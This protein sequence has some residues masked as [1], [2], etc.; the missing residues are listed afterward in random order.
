VCPRKITLLRLRSEYEEGYN[1]RESVSD[2]GTDPVAYHCFGWRAAMREF[3]EVEPVVEW[4]AEVID[5]DGQGCALCG[6]SA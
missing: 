5:I 1:K 3:V 6:V 2:G 4:M